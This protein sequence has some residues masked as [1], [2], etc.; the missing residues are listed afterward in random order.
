MADDVRERTDE[1]LAD[2]LRRRQDLARPAPADLSSLAARAG[3]RAS[4]QRAVDTLD[5]A[6]LQVLEG[7]PATPSPVDSAAVAALL[8]VSRAEVESLLD[9]LWALA[10]VWRS[11]EGLRVARTVSEV[12]P[13]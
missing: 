2:L 6:H 12:I 8:G 3:T 4:V 1:Q 10:L 5:L 9:D 13:H 7:A 11:P